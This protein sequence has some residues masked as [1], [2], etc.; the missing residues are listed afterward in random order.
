MSGNIDGV[1]DAIFSQLSGAAKGVLPSAEETPFWTDIAALFAAEKVRYE[2]AQTD[3]EKAKAGKNLIVIQ[4]TI[5]LRLA[6]KKIMVRDTIENVAK[7]VTKAVASQFFPGI[8]LL[9]G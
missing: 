4:K 6:R 7:L 3:E 9:L 8:G 1:R 5:E 2:A